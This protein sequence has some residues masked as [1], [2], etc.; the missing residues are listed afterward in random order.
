MDICRV[1]FTHFFAIGVNLLSLLAQWLRRR[2]LIHA[3]DGISLSLFLQQ[4]VVQLYF[5]HPH[6][7]MQLE[8]TTRVIFSNKHV[9][10]MLRQVGFTLGIVQRDEGVPQGPISSARHH[11]Q[12]L[13]RRLP[14]E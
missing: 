12:I 9:H 2:R 3:F 5:R 11:I 6:M 7:G 10:T 1:V 8:F 4:S 14:L 13:A